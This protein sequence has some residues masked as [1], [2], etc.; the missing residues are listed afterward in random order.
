MR[1]E[2]KST[3]QDRPVEIVE[4]ADVISSRA[5]TSLLTSNR[6]K[7]CSCSGLSRSKVNT[8]PVV[9]VRTY[10]RGSCS[11]FY[12]LVGQMHASKP[13]R[14]THLQDLEHR[15][16]ILLQPVFEVPRKQSLVRYLR[17][18]HWLIEEVSAEGTRC[19]EAIPWA[20]LRN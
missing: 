17:V 12:V 20:M 7:F 16:E 14:N 13:T 3:S 2:K 18:Q 9:C 1:H 11:R 5:L 19:S 8:R 15:E 4:H 10:G 6:N